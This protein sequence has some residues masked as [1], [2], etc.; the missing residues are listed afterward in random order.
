MNIDKRTLESLM[1]LPDEKLIKMLSLVTGK[2]EF[3]SMTPS[4]IAGLRKAI[5]EVTDADIARA[6]ELM[7]AYKD[8]KR[9]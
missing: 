4:S 3:R 2:S 6:L 1:E 5:A 8:G 7:T 9:R